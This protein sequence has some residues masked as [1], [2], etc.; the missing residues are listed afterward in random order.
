MSQE[1][2]NSNKPTLYAYQARESGKG[3]TYWTRIGAAWPIKDG[4]FSIQLDCLPLDGRI[5]CM[6]PKDDEQQ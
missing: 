6:T 5:I 4:G 1:T 3:K 2:N